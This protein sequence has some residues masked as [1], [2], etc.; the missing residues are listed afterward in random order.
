MEVGVGKGG[1]AAEDLPNAR[2]QIGGFEGYNT[3]NQ[4]THGASKGHISHIEVVDE[5]FSAEPVVFTGERRHARI[6]IFLVGIKIDDRRGEC[7]VLLRLKV[8]P[9]LH[10]LID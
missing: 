1:L 9:C 6:G 2:R 7:E 5:I 3:D 10:F 8:E 4:F